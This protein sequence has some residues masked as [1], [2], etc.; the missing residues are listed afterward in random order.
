MKDY[1]LYF[2]VAAL[3]CIDVM[4]MTTWQILDPFYRET[5]DLYSEVR[6]WRACFLSSLGPLT[7]QAVEDNE[8][9][10]IPRIEFCRS[11]H[12]T[13][14]VTC[15]YIYKGVL[16]VGLLLLLMTSCNDTWISFSALF[17]P[18]KRDMCRFQLW[19]TPNMSEYR[20]INNNN[21]K[22]S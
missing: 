21:I 20:V 9:Q 2:V 14:F 22:R 13:I 18:G 3:V 5:K 16:M 4:T 15:I 12:I 1:Q 19:T 17:W 6:S 8:L 11:K 10:I 7:E